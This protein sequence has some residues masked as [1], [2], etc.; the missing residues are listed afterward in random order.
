MFCVSHT[1]GKVNSVESCSHTMRANRRMSGHVPVTH[2]GIH[3]MLGVPRD[4]LDFSSNVNPLGPTRAVLDAI[5]R[6]LG[7]VGIYP[8]P[9]STALKGALRSYTG[10][11]ASRIVVGN[12]ASEI[13]YNFARAFL[14]DSTPVLVASPTFG[15]YEAAARLAGAPVTFFDTMDIGAD[16]EEFL[17]EIPRNGCVFVCNPNNPTGTLLRR[18]QMRR[19]LCRAVQ[20]GSLLFADEC[21]MELVHGRPES[22]LRDVARSNNLFVLRS[23]T[24]S[25]ALAGMRVG[26]GVGPKPIISVL[27]RTA[28]P[29][30]VSGL[31][32][33]AAQAALADTSYLGM[34]RNLIRTEAE[35]LRNAISG[36]DGLEC[37]DGSA[38]Y[39]L[40]RTKINSTMLQQRLLRRGILVRDCRS[41][42]GLGGN[43]IRIA[44]RTRR[45]NM[46]LA[47]A[48]D[49]TCHP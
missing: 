24:K 35:Y 43:Y 25:F 7:L 17:S 19:I 3:S 32:Q 42:R 45:E 8:D 16:L 41:F 6:N 18:T 47:G 1:L 40:V 34:A 28:I 10:V 23:L 15:E 30:N 39:I 44:V 26:Y 2:G 22:M 36:V 14:S 13:I 37:L 38:N 49:D 29:W 4:V 48:L 46:K 11:P 21:F 5:R 27:D 9:R 12:G 33:A 31:A 20:R